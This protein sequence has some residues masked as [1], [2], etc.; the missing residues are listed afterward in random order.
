[1]GLDTFCLICGGPNYFKLGHGNDLK[2]SNKEL[3]E[4]KWLGSITGIDKT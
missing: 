4:Y 2:M 1:M 3:L